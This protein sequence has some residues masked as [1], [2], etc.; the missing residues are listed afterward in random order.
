MDLKTPDARVYGFLA[1]GRY[2]SIVPAGIYDQINVSRDAIGTGPYKMV[3]FNPNDH[4]KYVANPNFWKK[5]LPY[6]DAI[7]LK[8]IPDEQSRIA[9]L[10]AG[11]IDGATVSADS[12]DALRNDSDL[13]VLKGGTAAFR[14]LQFTIKRRDQA[15]GRHARPAGGQLRDQ[16]PDHHRQ[17]LRRLRQVL[18][19]VPPGYGPW[20]LTQDELKTKYEKYDLPKAK[21]LMAAAGQSKGFD[22]T[23]TTFSTPLDFQQ[24][25]ALIKSQLKA[26]DINVN[27]VA[28]DPGTFAA[29]NGVGKFEWDLTARGMR[30]DVDGYMDEY[31]PIVAVYKVWFPVWKNA[32][33]WRA[34]R[35]RPHHA[36]SGQAA[37]DVQGRSGAAHERACRRSARAGAKFQVVNKRVKNMY[38]AFDDFNTG[39]RNTVWLSS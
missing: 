27:I 30:G 35:Q 38:V 34:D 29:N 23:M 6:M 20:P 10:R 17:G 15:V 9:A 8:I 11:A 16:P 31:N 2:S 5:G 13:V 37:A 7:T 26:I 1:W 19:H 12:A 21:A 33:V 22:V 36:R 18:G 14:E 32:K 24:V 25:A 4:V 39:L 3:G 28:Q